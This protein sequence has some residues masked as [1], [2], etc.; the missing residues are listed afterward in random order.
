MSWKWQHIKETAGMPSHPIR[1]LMDWYD[2]G[3]HINTE[4]HLS[5]AEQFAKNCTSLR[6]L[7]QNFL[8]NHFLTPNPLSMRHPKKE[9]V[10]QDSYAHLLR[11]TFILGG[12]GMTCFL[13]V[14][15]ILPEKKDFFFC[16]GPGLL[17]RSQGPLTRGS[18][19]Q[20]SPGTLNRGQ[21]PD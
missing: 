1:H 3:W 16:F 6:S 18:N 21:G 5:H 8:S 15:I 10:I 2:T 14:I 7:D 13:Q 9:L 4:E 20:T 19:P 17:N 11:S 12:T